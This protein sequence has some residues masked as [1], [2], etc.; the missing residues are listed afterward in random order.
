MAA[1]GAARSR[2]T[3]CCLT[4]GKHYCVWIIPVSDKLTT[5]GAI[6]HADHFKKAG[7]SKEEFMLHECRHMSPAREVYPRS[8]L[9][10]EAS[11]A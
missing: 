5:I 8:H 11:G 1:S 10:N 3:H 6:V 2:A 9:Q 4:R 7:M